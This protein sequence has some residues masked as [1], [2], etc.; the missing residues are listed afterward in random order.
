MTAV[1]DG[2]NLKWELKSMKV[3]STHRRVCQSPFQ[4]LVRR[5]HIL[6]RGRDHVLLKKNYVSYNVLPRKRQPKQAAHVR[7]EIEV[8]LLL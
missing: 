3:K 5:Q 1:V 2:A 7:T 6:Y 8:L 4:R